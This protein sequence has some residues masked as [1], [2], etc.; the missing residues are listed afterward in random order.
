MSQ[1]NNLEPLECPFCGPDGRLAFNHNGIMC[2][3]CNVELRARTY[4]DALMRWNKRS[5]QDFSRNYESH[6]ILIALD[7]L[8]DAS[9]LINRAKME[10]DGWRKLTKG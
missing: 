1:L 3:E 2:C 6:D 4:T 8:R 7:K 10:I 9:D 5:K